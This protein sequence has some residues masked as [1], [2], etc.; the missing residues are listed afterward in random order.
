MGDNLRSRKGEGQY[1][2]SRRSIPRT[3]V[4]TITSNSDYSKDRI[5]GGQWVE[6]MHHRRI[7]NK[8]VAGSGHQVS[9]RR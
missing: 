8:D 3:K 5:L 4:M 2:Y 1:H 7:H 9:R 6:G